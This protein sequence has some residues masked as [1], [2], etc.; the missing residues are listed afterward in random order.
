MKPLIKYRGGKTREIPHLIQHIPKKY[1]TYLEP[2]VGGGALFFHL[3]PEKATIGDINKQLITFYKQLKSNFH[4]LVTQ[5]EDLQNTYEQNQQEY[6]R[7]KQENPTNKV[8]NKNEA[9]Y[10]H[11]RHIFNNPNDTYLEGTVYYFINKTAYS[12]MIR[13]NKKGEYNV[14]FGRY[15][16]FNTKLITTDP[17]SYTHLSFKCSINSCSIKGLVISTSFLFFFTN[18]ASVKILL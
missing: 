5:L 3:E 18:P 2:F 11:L 14:P 7:L 1:D 4:T 13:Y 16:N 17:V 12:G 10:Y 9:L 8:E 15:K 6:E